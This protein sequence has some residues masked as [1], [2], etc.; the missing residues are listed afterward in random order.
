VLHAPLISQPPTSFIK[1]SEV[2]RRVGGGRSFRRFETLQL[3][4]VYCQTLPAD[5]GTTRLRNYGTYGLQQHGVT[6]Q[7]NLNISNLHTH[8]IMQSPS[9][10]AKS[11]FSSQLIPR[12]LWNMKIHYRSHKSPP[13]VLVLSHS[14]SCRSILIL[15]PSTLGSPKWSLS[16]RFPHQDPV[17]ASLL[18]HTRYMPSPSNSS[19]FYH[20]G[21]SAFKISRLTTV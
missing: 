2:S 17:Y 7:K 11:S 16:L 19:R 13:H 20:I 12:I 4:H 14:T 9:R 15:S 8:S 21:N 1:S 10:D 5:E 18:P 6:S 3:F